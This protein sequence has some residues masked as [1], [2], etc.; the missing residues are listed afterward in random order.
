MPNQDPICL[1]PNLVP[2]LTVDIWEHAFYITYKNRKPDY[3]K[4][5]W[6]IINW[7]NLE[8]RYNSGL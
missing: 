8:E 4:E 3:M 5:I 7:R 6:K 1:Y 2:I